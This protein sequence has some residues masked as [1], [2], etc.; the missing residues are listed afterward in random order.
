[1]NIFYLIQQANGSLII[2]ILKWFKFI[3]G[4]KQCSNKDCSSLISV[5]RWQIKPYH[6]P[7]FDSSLFFINVGEKFDHPFTLDAKYWKLRENSSWPVSSE[8]IAFYHHTNPLFPEKEWIGPYYLFCTKCTKIIH[9]HEKMEDSRPKKK[10]LGGSRPK[11]K[12]LGRR[13][14]DDS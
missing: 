10:K 13:T 7:L 11:R 9:N 1:M 3:M 14:V 2:K 4:G 5:M 8:F 12:K 6:A